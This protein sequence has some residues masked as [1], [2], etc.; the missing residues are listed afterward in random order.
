MVSYLTL[1]SI[2]LIP[3]RDNFLCLALRQ[4]PLIPHG[5][6][7]VVWLEEVYLKIKTKTVMLNNDSAFLFTK[8]KQKQTGFNKVSKSRYIQYKFSYVQLKFKSLQI[9]ECHPKR[10]KQPRVTKL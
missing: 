6:E 1:N 7:A 10:Y 8:R 5:G 4:D 3:L 2:P 9:T